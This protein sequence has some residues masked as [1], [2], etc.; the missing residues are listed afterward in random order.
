MTMRWMNASNA[1]II[2]HRGRSDN[3]LIDE[4]RTPLHLRPRTRRLDGTVRWTV[5]KQLEAEDYEVK[6]DAPSITNRWHTRK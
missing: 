5:V 3:V 6:E 4:A 2:L 1:G